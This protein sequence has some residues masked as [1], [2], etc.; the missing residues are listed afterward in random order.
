MDDNLMTDIQPLPPQPPLPTAAG[1]SLSEMILSLD[2]A[3]LLAKQLTTT[4]DPSHLDQ[5]Y[6]S[7]HQAH[8]NLSTFLLPNSNPQFAPPPNSLSSATAAAEGEPMQVGDGVLEI[9]EDS[10]PNNEV[11]MVE[12][13]FR[14]CCF[15]KNK[16]QKRKLSP[17]A[18]VVAEEKR[19]S[20][21]G[22][23]WGGEVSSPYVSKLRALELSLKHCFDSYVCPSANLNNLHSLPF[24]SNREHYVFTKPSMNVKYAE[25]LPAV[26][27]DDQHF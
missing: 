7:L 6:S 24:S 23:C 9:E 10:K 18:A 8:H 22:Y 2:E 25:Q 21:Y 5:I 19:F 16:R 14:D 3:S 1:E 12:E 13:R 17:S 26:T 27:A 20:D 4:I 15:I 11:D